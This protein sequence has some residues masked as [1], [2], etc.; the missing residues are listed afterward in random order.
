[1]L[2][3]PPQ[4]CLVDL[5][6]CTQSGWTVVITWLCFASDLLLNYSSYFVMKPQLID[7]M[8]TVKFLLLVSILVDLFLFR[9]IGCPDSFLIITIPTCWWHPSFCNFFHVWC[10]CLNEISPPTSY[11]ISGF[12]IIDYFHLSCNRYHFCAPLNW[13]QKCFGQVFPILVLFFFI[14]WEN[15]CVQCL[16]CVL[17]TFCAWCNRFNEFYCTDFYQSEFGVIF[18]SWNHVGY[19]KKIM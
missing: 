4:P 16:K 18:R 10:V 7:W 9:W 19:R 6:Y 1:M 17:W 14:S 3:D 13:L 15:G 8:A 12:F 5:L 11:L 2:F